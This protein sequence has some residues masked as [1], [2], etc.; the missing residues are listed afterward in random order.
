[1]TALRRAQ[2]GNM[3]LRFN[4]IRQYNDW[5]QLNVKAKLFHT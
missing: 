1:M 2:S 5:R 3:N 4:G